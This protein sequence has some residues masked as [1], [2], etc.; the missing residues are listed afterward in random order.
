MPHLT[1]LYVASVPASVTFYESV[2]GIPPLESSPG[3][4]MFPLSAGS[5]LG[6]WKRDA[7]QPPVVGPVAGSELA[8]EHADAASLNAFRDV[9]WNAGAKVVQDIVQADFGTTF[10]VVDPDGHR[11]RGLVPSASPDAAA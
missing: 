7:V 5:M 2:L 4:A 11:L 1:I 10:C 6:L 3:F 9:C 8:F